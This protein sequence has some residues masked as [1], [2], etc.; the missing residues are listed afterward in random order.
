[1]VLTYR[2]A[3]D[4]HQCGYALTAHVE[5]HCTCN[6][7]DRALLYRFFVLTH[8]VSMPRKGAAGR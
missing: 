3:V 2:D 1:M 7:V 6:P 4:H 5:T 8:T